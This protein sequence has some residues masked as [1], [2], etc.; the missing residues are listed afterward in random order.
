[1]LTHVS[2][3]LRCVAALFHHRI[4]SSH[5][6]SKTFWNCLGSME[7]PSEFHFCLLLWWSLV[8]LFVTLAVEWY[9]LDEFNV[10]T[11]ANLFIDIVKRLNN[12]PLWFL[13]TLRKCSNWLHKRWLDRWDFNWWLKLLLQSLSIL[14]EIW[15]RMLILS[16][17]QLLL[18]LFT[19]RV[20]CEDGRVLWL[21]E[22]SSLVLLK[23][24]DVSNRLESLL[25]L[26][27]LSSKV[28]GERIIPHHANILLSVSSIWG[29]NSIIVWEV[30][31]NWLNWCGSMVR[32]YKIFIDI[33]IRMDWSMQSS[34]NILLGWV[35]IS[36]RWMRDMVRGLRSEII[37]ESPHPVWNL[38]GVNVKRRVHHVGKRIVCLSGVDGLLVHIVW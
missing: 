13:L 2:G 33:F 26:L 35:Y 16:T 32:S 38:V 19:F 6:W 25:S 10:I 3:F 5:H 8:M 4:M 7:S 14:V 27:N 1:M 30:V 11:W 28:H 20:H 22:G 31:A 17:I 34:W 9:S 18:E 21:S 15:Q 23:F 36:K 12:L 37:V 24:W 29:H